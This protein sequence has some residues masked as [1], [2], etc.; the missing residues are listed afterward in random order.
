MRLLI[1]LIDSSFNKH[2][3]FLSYCS[4]SISSLINGILIHL[5]PPLPR[6]NSALLI[7]YTFIPCSLSILFV[8]LFLSYTTTTPGAMHSVFVPSFHCSLSADIFSPPA[9]GI[10][11]IFLFKYFSSISSKDPFNS[12][13]FRS[14]SLS[15]MSPSV[16]SN[17]CNVSIIPG[18]YVNLS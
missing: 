4:L 7:S 17:T 18:W 14:S 9:Q 11:V 12:I 16:I 6:D 5:G 3:Q 10:R 15:G 8:M 2:L 13:T 1:F